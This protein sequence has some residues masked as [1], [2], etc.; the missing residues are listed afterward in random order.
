M[1]NPR[2]S[3]PPLRTYGCV[4]LI[5][6]Q[7]DFVA[8]VE[9]LLAS[10]DYDVVPFTEPALL[11]QFLDGRAQLLHEEQMILSGICQA[12]LQT[13][14]TAAVEALRFFARPG[15]LEIPLVLVS[16]Y[17]MAP[18]TGL[19]VCARHR[20]LALER[21]LLTGV[22]DTNVAVS[23]FN[24]GLIEQYIRKQSLALVEDLKSAVRG[25]LLAS[26][27]RRGAQLGAVFAPALASALAAP[28]VAD[29]IHKMLLANG[30]R[31][32]MMLGAP[33]GI[34]GVTA[35]GK[36]VWI[37]LETEPSLGELDDVLQLAR[38]DAA[39]R[40]RV[41]ARESL[42][43]ADFMQQAGLRG[44]EASVTALSS[45]PLLL[46]AVHWLALD[47]GFAPVVHR[48]RS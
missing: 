9:T 30:V 2:A 8:T 37:Q 21:I 43:A 46:A 40:Q 33:Q 4:A 18:E 35:A 7:E 25:R 29:E 10:S 32:Y 31:E 14:G 3:L 44:G 26:A 1:N 12:Q 42:I 27:A 45:A 24:A 41:A 47:P 23:A 22:A 17:A 5:D 19:S 20:H 39:G 11:H 28:G 6:D 34:L 38:V 16:D 36:A 15:R 48:A 13:D